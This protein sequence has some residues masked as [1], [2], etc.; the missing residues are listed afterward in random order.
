[1]K[2][3]SFLEISNLLQCVF[4]RFQSELHISWAQQKQT[5]QINQCLFVAQR[6]LLH[7]CFVLG[8]YLDGSHE[9]NR[10][11]QILIIISFSVFHFGALKTWQ[12]NI[13]VDSNGY[14]FKFY[15][16]LFLLFFCTGL[17]MISF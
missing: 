12:S 11:L 15:K 8:F 1:M 4:D 3:H 7:F 6:G 10:P 5:S 13:L 9:T 2:T 16:L 14:I 17:E